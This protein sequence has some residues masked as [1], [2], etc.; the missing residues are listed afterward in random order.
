MFAAH[1]HD[2]RCSSYT[3]EGASHRSRVGTAHH[4][5]GLYPRFIPAAEK[6]GVTI[7]MALTEKQGGSDLRANTTRAV[8]LGGSTEFELMGHK[9]FC[10]APMSDAFLTL[11]RTEAGLSC[12]LP[13]WCPDGTRNPFHIQ[14]LKDKLGDRSNASAEIEYRKTWLV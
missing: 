2:L 4:Q 8:A 11:A 3:T 12:F 10:S 14:R 9:W 5:R 13:R 1:Y 7:G 6:T